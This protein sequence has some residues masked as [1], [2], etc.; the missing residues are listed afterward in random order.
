[1]LGAAPFLRFQAFDRH[2]QIQENG[3]GSRQPPT[4]VTMDYPDPLRLLEEKLSAYRSPILPGLPSFC[5]GG[6][7]HP[8][9]H[10]AAHVAPPPPPPDDDRQLPD[11][12]VAFYDRMVIFDHM[13]KTVIPVANAHVD[14]ANPA[15]GYQA[16][17]TQ[18]DRLVERLQQNVADLQLTD[19]API[20]HSRR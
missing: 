15:A 20:G 3:P 6:G 7:G 8:G 4:L 17:C 16:A 13:N 19:I 2:V 14:P 18:V 9:L 10:H 5:G 1:F 12:C 11:L